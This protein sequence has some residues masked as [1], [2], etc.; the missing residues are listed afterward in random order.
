MISERL[1]CDFILTNISDLK[2]FISKTDMDKEVLEMLTNKEYYDFCKTSKTNYKS[3]LQMYYFLK[4][5]HGMMN[6]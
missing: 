5:D 2:G 1:L 3:L 6:K 4:K